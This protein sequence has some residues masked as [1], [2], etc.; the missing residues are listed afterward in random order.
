MHHSA[1]LHQ[2]SAESSANADQL[3][4]GAALQSAAED[5]TQFTYDS[6]LDFGSGHVE[7]THTVIASLATKPFMI[8]SGLSGAGKTRLA[9]ALGQ[10]FGRERYLIQPVRPDWTSPDALLGNVMTANTADGRYAWYVPRTLEFV[11]SALRSPRQPFLL[12]LEEMNL[13]HVEQYLADILSGMESQHPIVPN[14][15]HDGTAWRMRTEQPYLSWPENLYLVG[16]INI[17]ETTYA[18]SPKVIDRATSIEFRVLP[19]SLHP[20]YPEANAPARAHEQHLTTLLNR[21][22]GGDSEWRGRDQLAHSLQHLHRLLFEHD[23]EFGHRVFR[24]C[25]RFGA[26]MFEAGC[27]NHAVALDYAILYRILPKFEHRR[28]SLALLA[29]LASFALH[30][31]VRPTTID[32]LAPPSEATPV[33][34][35]SYSKALRLARRAHSSS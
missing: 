7:L 5:F 23:A 32:P 30:G 15:Q 27:T 2:R 21:T 18:F 26:M 19:G 29:A 20:D 10:W 8:F 33:L 34:P 12:V 13:A 1:S 24:E 22:N 14:L 25:M 6:G 17:D 9:V 11:L 35:N 4:G 28:Q 16:T 3:R 31:S